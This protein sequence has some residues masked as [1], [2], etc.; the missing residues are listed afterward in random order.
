MPGVVASGYGICICL[1]SQPP[2]RAVRPNSEASLLLCKVP[3]V[4]PAPHPPRVPVCI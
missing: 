4:R 2:P 1:V 3:R